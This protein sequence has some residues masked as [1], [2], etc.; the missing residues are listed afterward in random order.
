MDYSEFSR[1]QLLN[2]INDLE[3]LNFELLREKEHETRL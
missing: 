3:M 2:R 1:E